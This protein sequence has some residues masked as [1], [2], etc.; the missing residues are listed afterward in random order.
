MFNG[1]SS[2]EVIEEWV[3]PAE[4]DS[5]QFDTAV[6]IELDGQVR[7]RVGVVVQSV[8]AVSW[9]LHSDASDAYSVASMVAMTAEGGGLNA[10]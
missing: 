5:V 3:A 9:R 10:G 7:E 4:D 8:A 6:V 1:A 2:G